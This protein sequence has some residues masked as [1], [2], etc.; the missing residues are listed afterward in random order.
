MQDFYLFIN[1][2]YLQVFKKKYLGFRR[3]LNFEK[4]RNDFYV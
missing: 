1:L 3:I 2:I 4:L